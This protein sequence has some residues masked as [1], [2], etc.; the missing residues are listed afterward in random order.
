MKYDLYAVIGSDFCRDKTLED[1]V[2]EAVEGGVDV[3]QLREKN[4]KAV[5]YIQ[6]AKKIRV[7]TRKAGVR[8][9][10]NDHTDVGLAVDADGVHLGQDDLPLEIARKILGPDKIIGVSV[11]NLSQA[12]EAEEA[13]ADYLGVGPVFPTSS[14]DDAVSPIGIL[15]LKEIC[16]KVHIPV[17]AIGGINSGNAGEV[18]RAGACGV[19]VIS[20][21]F[22]TDDIK[23]SAS[24]LKRKIEVLKC[25]KIR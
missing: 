12:L 3:V 9:I 17:V 5:E 8:F 6:I 13:G 14:K 22:G 24:G 10:V 19:A 7:I 23:M 25:E 2:L 16:D 18:L 15:V 11:R 4:V 20:A 1:M 21:I